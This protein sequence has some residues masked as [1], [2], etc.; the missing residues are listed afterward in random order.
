MA[1]PDAGVA[2]RRLDDRAARLQQTVALGRVDHGDR[3]PVLHAAAGVRRLELGHDLAGEVGAPTRR[4]RT[5]GV[6]PIRSSGESAISGWPGWSLMA[7]PRPARRTGSAVESTVLPRGRDRL[8]V[9][10]DVV[11][12]VVR[13]RRALAAEPRDQRIDAHRRGQHDRHLGQ[14]AV[15]SLAEGDR[16]ARSPPRRQERAGGATAPGAGGGPRFR[17]FRTP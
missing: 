16:R 3:R 2:R 13:H 8:E 9:G 7:R 5:S 6:L 11:V 4:S 15:A 10:L 1:R 14:G 12:A 17:Q